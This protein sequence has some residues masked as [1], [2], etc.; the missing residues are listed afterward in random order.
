[1]KEA[2]LNYFRSDRSYNG[3]VALVMKYSHKLGFKRMLNL[4][5]ESDYL[6]GIVH[7]ELR[8]LGGITSAE[9]MRLTRLP[10]VKQEIPVASAQPQQGSKPAAAIPPK[11]KKKNP[12]TKPATKSPKKVSRKK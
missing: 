6:L 3:G 7:E 4:Q 5:H 10:I 11:G 12:S 2:I 9:F 8:E 1:M